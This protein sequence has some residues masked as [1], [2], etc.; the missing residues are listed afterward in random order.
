MEYVNFNGKQISKITLGTVQLGM[1]YGI[2]NTDG[3]PSEQ[4]AEQVLSAAVNGGITTFDT[5][6]DYGTSEKV[7]GEFFK[8]S[9]DNKPLIVTKFGVGAWEDNLSELDLEQKIRE[10][11]E[12]SL[13]NLG[14]NKLPLL[15]SHN[16]KDLQIYDKTLINVLRKLQ[17]EN[18]V[19]RVGASLNHFSFI[20]KVIESEIF[21]AV[22]LP[23]NMMDVKNV[24]GDGIKKLAEKNIA[25]FIRSVFLQGLFFRDPESLPNGILQNAK[26]PLKKVRKIAEEENMSI[27]GLAISYIRDLEGVSSLVMGA[28]KP[29][30]VKEN[31]ELIN[32]KKISD[33]AREKIVSAFHDIDEKVLCPWLWNK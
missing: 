30:Q 27:A 31:I 19:D 8:C 23:L 20:D 10:Q 1:N 13:V 18:L 24:N 7:I 29:E 4:L 25:V 33:S 15:L 12:T 2:N 3:K 28:E 22:Q 16:E 21:E 9:K 6:S 14:Y 32:V 17:K 26:T 5:S 11:V